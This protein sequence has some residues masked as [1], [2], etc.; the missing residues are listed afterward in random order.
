M[1]PDSGFSPLSQMPLSFVFGS[2]KRWLRRLAVV[3]SAV[4]RLPLEG[5]RPVPE[6]KLPEM[7]VGRPVVALMPKNCWRVSG[8][9]RLVAPWSRNQKSTKSEPFSPSV[10]PVK[11]SSL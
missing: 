6:P 7:V 5:L 8:S 11:A 9:M 3:S 4:L 10:R 2:P 1:S